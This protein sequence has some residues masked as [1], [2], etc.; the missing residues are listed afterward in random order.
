MIVIG[1]TVY[2]II[3]RRLSRFVAYAAVLIKDSLDDGWTCKNDADGNY[4]PVKS[5]LNFGLGG[6]RAAGFDNRNHTSTDSGVA[7]FILK[8]RFSAQGIVSPSA[9]RLVDCCRHHPVARI[10]KR[11]CLS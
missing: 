7:T 11:W 6:D 9:R 3:G 1:L 2:L 4:H 5:P 8:L 10:G